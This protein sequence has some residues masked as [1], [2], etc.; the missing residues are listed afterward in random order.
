M[1]VNWLDD[2]ELLY[3]KMG[4]QKYGIRLLALWK[5][6]SGEP[7]TTVC[8]FLHKTH[9]TIRKWRRTY[10]EEGLEALLRIRSGRGRKSRLWEIEQLKK[11]IEALQEKRNGGRIRCQD[12]VGMVA[13][14][15][16]V[17]YSRSGMYHVL[18]RLNFSWITARSKHPKQDPEAQEVFKKNFL[19]YVQNCHPKGVPLEQVDIW[20]QDE[21]RVGQQG[22]QTRIWAR[23]GTRPRVVKQQQFLCQYIFGAVCPTQKSCAA[24]IVPCANHHGLEEHLEEISFQDGM[25]LL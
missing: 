10:E 19:E 21:A 2:F 4:Q 11:D 13:Q 7:E 14:K 6:Q 16:G 22:T 9:A 23:K 18:N 17:H 25:L 12:I 3:K 1:K 15:Y 20:F 8:K 24:I 5:I